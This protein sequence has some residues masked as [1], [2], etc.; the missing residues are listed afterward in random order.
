MKRADGPAE[1]TILVSIKGP[2]LEIPSL[3]RQSGALNGFTFDLVHKM[4][5]EQGEKDGPGCTFCDGT[6]KF[7]APLELNCEGPG[8]VVEDMG[9]R[10]FRCYIHSDFENDPEASETFK[11]TISIALT[12]NTFLF[13]TDQI[14]ERFHEAM[15]EEIV[16]QCDYFSTE[17]KHEIMDAVGERIQEFRQADGR[18]GC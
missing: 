10:I 17:E 7:F 6:Q 9:S 8:F 5:L 1:R 14:S 2:S 13:M 16:I 15:S 3:P 11:D 12:A 18:K 4:I